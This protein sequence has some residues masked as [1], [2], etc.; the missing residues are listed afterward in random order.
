MEW[1]HDGKID[2]RD[3]MQEYVIYSETTKN[4][5]SDSYN[6][7][8]GMSGIGIGLLIFGIVIILFKVYGC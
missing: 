6:A 4:S 1:N 3:S 2:E 5:K 7:G 8:T